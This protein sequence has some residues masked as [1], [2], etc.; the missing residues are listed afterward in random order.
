MMRCQ[1]VWIRAQLPET[2]Y[3]VDS[4]E[5]PLA[6]KENFTKAGFISPVEQARVKRK[7]NENPVETQLDALKANKG[8]LA[9]LTRHAMAALLN[10]HNPEVDYHFSALEI[11]EM[12]NDVID[13]SLDVESTKNKF[14]YWNN[15]PDGCPLN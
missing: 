4:W 12:Y 9:A 8:N 11:I 10:A 2:V 14:D 3:T 1:L 7:K 13:G 15:G 5:S 6:T